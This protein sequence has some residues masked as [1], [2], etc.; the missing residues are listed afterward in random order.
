LIGLDSD[1]LIAFELSAHPRHRDARDILRR[2]VASG[3]QLAISAQVLAE[4]VHVV[5]D[6]RRFSAPM[7]VDDAIARASDWIDDRESVVVVSDGEAIRRFADWM[8]KH[9]LGRRRVLDTM[10]A[11]TYHLAGIKHLLTFNE[12]DFRVFGSF[13]FV[14]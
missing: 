7:S 2:V 8:A 13:Q 14:N 10:L 9:H 12:S 5:T 3:E 1:F 4:F 6:Q 11:A